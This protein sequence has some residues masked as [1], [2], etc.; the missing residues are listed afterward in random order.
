MRAIGARASGRTSATRASSRAARRSR[1]SSSRTPTSGT[2]ARSR[3]SCAR[4]RSPGSS[5]SSGR[6]R[7]LTAY[8]NTIY[9]GN[10]AYGVDQ[11]ALTYFGHHAKR[12]T[13]AEAALLAGIPADPSRYDP[14][15][16]PRAPVRGAARS[17]TMLELGSISQARFDAPTGRALPLPRR[18]HLPDTR[19]PGGYFANYVN[20][21]LVDKYRTRGVFGGGLR[22]RR[23][24][25]STS[26]RSGTGRSRAG[27]RTRTG[28]RR[29]SSPSTRATG[30]SRR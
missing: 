8:L 27:S 21:Q 16:N 30:R 20:Q 26:R 7:I 24:S 17:S 15:T 13:L 22:S 19:G 1:S 3:G 25:T 11:A 18:G 6:R 2:S 10:G 28:L 14:V 4:R 12:L 23:R 9:F 5:S 29:R